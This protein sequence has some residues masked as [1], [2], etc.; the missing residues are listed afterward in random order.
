[1]LTKKLKIKNKTLYYNNKAS[2][3]NLLYK[4]YNKD[5]SKNIIN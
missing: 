5:N 3:M 2:L 4:Q 1:M